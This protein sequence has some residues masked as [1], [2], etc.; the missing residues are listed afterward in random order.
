MRSRPKP[1]PETR[2]LL[3]R[4]WV[5]VHGC[6]QDF[7]IS[8][9]PFWGPIWTEKEG[10]SH[11]RLLSPGEVSGALGRLLRGRFMPNTVR[12]TARELRDDAPLASA[13]QG[14]GEVRSG[15]SRRTRGALRR[16]RRRGTAPG[17]E[18][19]PTNNHAGKGTFHG[20]RTG[21]APALPM[22]RPLGV[23]G[24]EKWRGD[25]RRGETRRPDRGSS[26]S[27]SGGTPA[28][29]QREPVGLT[30]RAINAGSTFCGAQA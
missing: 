21:L 19:G 1:P 24:S 6:R 22:S 7:F 28:S 15:T 3:D 10:A 14:R 12:A 25:C 4:M 30:N 11:M 18:P 17:R 13:T 16:C 26:R 27:G 20:Y 23:P 9:H 29:P 5:Y 8:A 2:R